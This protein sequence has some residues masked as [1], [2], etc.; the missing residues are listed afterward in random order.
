MSSPSIHR[1]NPVNH[2]LP[3]VNHGISV[4][5][6]QTPSRTI[7][8]ISPQGKKESNPS[9]L[10]RFCNWIGSI[11]KACLCCCFPSK[12]SAA[13]AEKPKFL[14]QDAMRQQGKT[15]IDNLMRQGS[16]AIKE[17]PCKALFVFKIDDKVVDAYWGYIPSNKASEFTPMVQDTLANATKGKQGSKFE[18]EGTFIEI[19]RKTGAIP[20]Y[21][22]SQFDQVGTLNADTD[23]SGSVQEQNISSTKA[24]DYL[25]NSFK[26]KCSSAKQE[27][28]YR[29]AML[30]LGHPFKRPQ[31]YNKPK[32]FV[33]E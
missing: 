16:A 25:K 11:F 32:N 19:I 15:F 33:A 26:G 30:N 18:V 22:F 8:S 9:C 2:S 10:E 3:T 21:N 6:S 24:E 27:Q 13:A 4:I 12:K 17:N 1:L 20:G 7:S 23:I 29:D 28:A 31:D 5:H 14:T